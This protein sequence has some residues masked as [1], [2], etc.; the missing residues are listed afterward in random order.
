MKTGTKL[1]IILFSIVSTAHLLRLLFDLNI[2]IESWNVPQ[3]I[4]VL[5]VV[6][7]GA[8]AL[9]LWRESK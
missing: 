3:W 7:P 4:S 1:A 9:M 5:G 8:I 2:S 6:G